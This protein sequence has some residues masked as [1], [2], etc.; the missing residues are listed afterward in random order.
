MSTPRLIVSSEAAQL[1]L[2]ATFLVVDRLQN[3]PTHAAFGD[4]E[5]SL[6]ERLIPIYSSEFVATDK[7]VQGFREL[8]RAVGCSP[9][10]FPCSIEGLIKFVR[11]RRALPRINLVVDCY[12][13]VSY[14]T[15]LTLG[16]HDL[17]KVAGNISLSVANGDEIFVPLGSDQLEPIKAGEYCYVD[18]ED[19]VLCR[20]DYRQCDKSKLTLTTRRCLFI[21]QGHAQTSMGMLDSARDRLMELLVRFGCVEA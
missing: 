16:A 13:A 11:K 21:V 3:Q 17:D 19:D 5:A 14:E 8:H 12:N 7:I 10:K 20:L 4:F 18:E 1:G 9:K 6:C 15:R 2:Q